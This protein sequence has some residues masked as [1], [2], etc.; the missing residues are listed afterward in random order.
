ML[1]AT[2]VLVLGL[3]PAFAL[4]LAAQE[5][6]GG[7]IG[8]EDLRV[9]LIDLQAKEFE[10]QTRAK[11][12]EEQLKPENIERSLAG[13]GSTKPEELRELRRRQLTVEKDRV[14]AQLKLL[15]TS[16]ERLET[17][18]RASETAAY[19]QSAD[20]YPV[21]QTLRASNASGSRWLVAGAAGFVAL[22]GALFMFVRMRKRSGD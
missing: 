20:G 8:S 12:L 18:V 5:S 13:I 19:Q 9:R 4:N 1:R 21:T 11:Q 14:N 22:A 10:L 3:A 7:A 16:R 6:R 15:A 2:L 17:A